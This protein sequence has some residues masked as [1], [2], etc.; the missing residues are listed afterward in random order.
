M[1]SRPAECG[2]SE[3]HDHF[4]ADIHIGLNDWAS[5]LALQVGNFGL[6]H[7]PILVQVRYNLGQMYFWQYA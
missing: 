4:L 2:R 5:L 7:T 1:S 6:A 3:K